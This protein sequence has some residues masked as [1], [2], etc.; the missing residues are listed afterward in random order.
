MLQ[1]QRSKQLFEERLSL[2]QIGS[3]EPFAE[4]AIDRG[5]R[6][7]GVSGQIEIAK[8]LGRGV[9]A[10]WVSNAVRSERIVW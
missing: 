2:L 7:V 1:P 4:P 5:R 6:L 8:H 10:E 3:V 9:L